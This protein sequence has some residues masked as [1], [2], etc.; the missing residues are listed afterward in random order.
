[1][2]ISRTRI[3]TGAFGRSS[4]RRRTARALALPAAALLLIA[5]GPVTAAAGKSSPFPSSLLVVR[6][7]AHRAR[8]ADRA[9]V[10][11]A[12]AY[13]DCKSAHKVPCHTFRRRLQRAGSSDARAQHALNRTVRRS[14]RAA[15]SSSARRAPS[16]NVSGDSLHWSAVGG[17]RSYI[18][19]RM[20]GS[21]SASFELVDGLSFTP[22]P[23]P[24]HVASY[25]VRAAARNARWSN[26]VSISYQP[27]AVAP[28][29]QAAPLLTVSGYTLHWTAVA[30]VQTYVLAATLPSG[31]VTYLEVGGTSLTPAPIA[32]ATVT[33]SIRTAVEGSAWSSPVQISYPE[34]APGEPNEEAKPTPTPTEE[35]AVTEASSSSSTTTTTTSAS[36]SSSSEAPPTEVPVSTESGQTF[37]APRASGHLEI[38]LIPESLESHETTLIKDL[39]ARTVRM[40]AEIEAPA[41][42]LAPWVE[43]YASAGIKILP[44]AGFEGRIPTAAQARNLATWAA[45]YGPGGT[46]WKGKS[47]P[48]SAAITDIEFG[49]ETRYASR[50]QRKQSML[51]IRGSACWRR[52]TKETADLRSGST[53][54]S[55]RC[56][57]SA[58]TSPDGR[59][60]LMGPNGKRA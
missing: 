10:R 17:A 32:G 11:A 55:R 57:I 37:E 34:S 9:L 48:E 3:S 39:G 51:P 40:E 52:R 50:K 27:E 47:L 56:Q 22:P 24:G 53:T 14:D 59:S 1:M 42:Q 36:T 45:A 7:A 16:L 26:Q 4:G 5:S 25:R 31:A 6:A 28:N 33:Y 19:E 60:T 29:P 20:I 8:E 46:F 58:A 18:V 38:G 49:N 12:I 44:L 21:Q 15:N 35:K 13:R 41:S 54:C 23:L 30:G 43:S 2:R